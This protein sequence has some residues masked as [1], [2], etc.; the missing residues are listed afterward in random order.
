LI[1]TLATRGRI[2]LRSGGV[3]LLLMLEACLTGQRALDEPAF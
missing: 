1:S 2:R 3:G